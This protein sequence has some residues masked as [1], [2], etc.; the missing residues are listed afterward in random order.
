MFSTVSAPL[1]IQKV[2]THGALAGGELIAGAFGSFLQTSA[3]TAGATAV[4][5][6]AGSAFASLGAAG[7]AAVLSSLSS[8]AGHGSEGAI[9][10][11]GSGLPPR[12]ARGR[13]GDDITG[14]K[15][16]RELI[17][18]NRNHYY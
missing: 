17:A 6:Q 2:F 15:A 8:A 10:I 1:V 14:D 13:P 16:V 9:I 7:T 3:T 12:S 18:R 5:S 4:A 11:A